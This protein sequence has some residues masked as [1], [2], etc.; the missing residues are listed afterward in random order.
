MLKNILR[1]IYHSILL[2]LNSIYDYR[3]YKRY[4][5]KDDKI[6]KTQKQLQAWMLQDKHR[7]EKAFSLPMPRPSFGKEVLERLIKNTIEYKEK[8]KKDKIYYISI[9]VIKSY[10]EFHTSRG[11]ELPNFLNGIIS[12]ID[13]DDFTNKEANISGYYYHTDK[14]ENLNAENFMRSRRSFRN[15]SPK[16]I[17]ENIMERITEL[18]ITAPSVCN[19]QHWKIHFF[20]NEKKLKILELQN[21]NKGFTSNIPMIAV[22]SSEL[23]AF[24]SPDE[25]NQPYTDGGIFAMNVMYAIE[26]LGLK[27]CPLNWCNSFRNERKFHKLGY[28]PNSE[29]VILII[30]FGYPADS[31]II[32]KSPRLN[33]EDFYTYN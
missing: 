6:N 23:S 8:Y 26:A 4:Y 24:Y 19:R 33:V 28:I 12:K 27:S 9:G 14:K 22:I 2:E 15:F 30:A 16:K 1:K 17:D 21:G 20:D 25:R 7:I 32:A 5:A 29:A 31:C 11:Y 3:K 18:S 10:K 13:N